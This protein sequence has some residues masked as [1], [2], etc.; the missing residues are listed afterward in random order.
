MLQ[1]FLEILNVYKTRLCDLTLLS[2]VVDE[3]F[4]HLQVQ[5]SSIRVCSSTVAAAASSLWTHTDTDSQ[6]AENGTKL[7]FNSMLFFRVY[8][9]EFALWFMC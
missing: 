9:Q 1:Y 2:G 6:P 8:T 3:V 5:G 7:G 4:R